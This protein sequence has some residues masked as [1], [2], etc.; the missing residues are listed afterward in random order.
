MKKYMIA[1]LLAGCTES[2]V[3]LDPCDEG[4]S[5][6]VDDTTIERCIE[7]EWVV[8]DCTSACPAAWPIGVCEPRPESGQTN[9]GCYEACT[10]RDCAPVGDP[11]DHCCLNA[12]CTV[13]L[14][15]DSGPVVCIPPL[16]GHAVCELGVWLCQP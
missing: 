6:C 15:S 9:C 4:S 7:G 5:A 8:E 13:G 3:D 1:I 11:I 10:T 16:T 2:F 12:D 14:T